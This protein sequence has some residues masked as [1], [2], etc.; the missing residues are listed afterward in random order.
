MPYKSEWTIDIPDTHLASLMFTSPTHPLS[1]SARLLV[2]T[3]KPDT[4]FFTPASFR[5]MCQRL[6]LGLQQNGIKPGDRVL[7]ASGNTPLYPVIFVG[8][9]MAGGV[10]T[11][12]N[13]T[14]VPRELAYQLQ[15]SEPTIF[16]CSK[17]IL[18]NGLEAAKIAGLVPNQIYV[19]DELLNGETQ[20]E[21]GCRWWGELLASEDTA[22]HFAWN[23]LSA[24]GEAANT[25]LALNYSSGTTG[26][27]KGVEITH[28]N[29][30][31]NILQGIHNYKLGEE[32]AE[33]CII[34]LPM[35]H[36]LSQR[37]I[38]TSLI[39]GSEVYIMPKY[40]LK[41]LLEN[42]QRFRITMLVMVPPV[43]VSLAK[44]PIVKNYD[45]SSVRIAGSGAAPLTK[46][47]CET[48][49]EMLNNQV[50]IKQGWGMTE[51]TCSFLFWI[52][53][54]HY[55]R[56]SVGEPLANCEAKI[57]NEDGTAELGTNERG[58]LWA[59]GPNVMR[60]YW[61]NPQATADTIN[62]DG[63]L[64]SGD[65]AY[66]DEEGR[67]F[68]VDRLKELIK[69][70]GVQVAP[71]EL[72]GQLLHHPAV[73]DAAVTGLKIIDGEYPRAYVVL[74]PGHHATDKEIMDFIKERVAPVKQL[75]GGVVFLDAIPKN[76][77]GKILRNVLKEMA[78]REAKTLS[79]ASKL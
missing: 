38:I 13:P 24:P 75:T 57:M 69:V 36:S 44:S 46:E 64:K 19:V 39:Q 77:S 5:L 27:P 26:L 51:L 48:I 10:F 56:S 60:G 52:P 66:V 18:T 67:F 62:P 58:E 70:K 22:R 29:Y 59:R 47:I 15:D 72:E 74:K 16:L 65:V 25:L 53:G 55:P 8:I 20:E 17:Q 71:A 40:E 54:K 2:D 63:W 3:E 35:Y 76:A 23:P 45:L 28:R 50:A 14:Y 31:A 32:M 4:H 33:R 79:G 37:R 11:G 9:I 6:A 41:S 30:V 43:A 73:A 42:I 78:Q 1:D 7:Y 61:K 68:I 12:A 49:E 34:Y 21:T